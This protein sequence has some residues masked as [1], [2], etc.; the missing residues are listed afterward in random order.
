[1]QK[2]ILEFTVFLSGFIVLT[3]EVVGARILWPYYGTSTFVWTAMIGIILASLSIGYYV[4]GRLADQKNA[5][6]ENLAN[7]I[8]YSWLAIACAYIIRKPLLEFLSHIINDIRIGSII[9]ATI[10]FLPA[11]ILLGM[12]SPYAVRLRID[13]LTSSGSTIGN[14][15]AIGTLGSILGTFISGFYLIPY[16]GMNTLLAGLPLVLLLLSLLIAPKHIPLIKIVGGILLVG[17]FITLD[18]V[19]AEPG[20]IIEKDTLYS[21]IRIFDAK[22]PVTDENLRTMGI[23]I[24]NHSRMSLDSDRL[25]N[26]Y[27]RYYHLVRHFFPGFT[28]WL[29]FGGAGYSFPKDYL[30]KYPKAKLDVVEIDPGV[31]ELAKKY[32]ALEDHPNLTIYHEDGRVFLNQNTKKYDAIFGDAFSSWYLVPYQLTTREAVQKEYDSLTESGV[33]ILNI[34]SS[35]EGEMSDFLRAEYRTYKEVF[36]QVY[37]LPVGHPHNAS[38]IQNITLVALK[39]S[40]PPLW[41]SK[42]PEI[43]E[44]LS[45]RWEKAILVDLPVLTDDYAPVDHYIGKFLKEIWN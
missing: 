43:N 17:I 28:S 8:L 11:S 44:Y 37:I 38:R 15:S 5:R 19:Y 34:I 27:T 18:R 9:A 33:V 4:G 13:K 14:M 22:D 23:N 7:M 40:I 29:M 36:P 31:T 12:V 6:I 42:D 41:T 20:I 21:H 26:E 10:L 16:F 24:E 2:Y 32:F 1:M 25:V 3:Y 39:S 45:H 35:L 30:A